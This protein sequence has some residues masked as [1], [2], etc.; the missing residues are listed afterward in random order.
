[1]TGHE[2][3]ALQALAALVPT[4]DFGRPG[5]LYSNRVRECGAPAYWSA[6]WHDT[7]AEDCETVS[8]WCRKHMI[9]IVR[10]ASRLLLRRGSFSCS[11]GHRVDTISDFVWDIA[12]IRD[13]APPR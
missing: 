12:P 8:L 4:C 5:Q 7:R 1:M 10:D 6:R 11:R 13:L 9:V 2:T 3:E